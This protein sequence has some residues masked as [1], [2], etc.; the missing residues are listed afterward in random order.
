MLESGC[1]LAKI[2]LRDARH[3]IV[4]GVMILMYRL[5]TNTYVNV[6]WD[7]PSELSWL[8]FETELELGRV[9]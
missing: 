3:H 5:V 8:V 2:K 6:C 1:V 9:N 4:M 7:A